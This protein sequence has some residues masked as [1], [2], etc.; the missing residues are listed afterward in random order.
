MNNKIIKNPEIKPQFEGC[1][2]SGFT[3]SVNLGD[4]PNF[5]LIIDGQEVEYDLIIYYKKDITR[6]I[7]IPILEIVT[8][9]KE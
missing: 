5:K 7:T 2:M 3:M 9:R 1:T 8:K 6:R 4:Q